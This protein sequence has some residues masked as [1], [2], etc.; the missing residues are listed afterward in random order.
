MSIVTSVLIGRI[1]LLFQYK[2][3]TAGF[4][5]YKVAAATHTI[6]ASKNAEQGVD[7]IVDSLR[8]SAG[9]LMYRCYRA[10]GETSHE[11]THHQYPLLVN[12]LNEVA[13][14]WNFYTTHVRPVINDVNNNSFIG[15]LPTREMRRLRSLVK[16]CNQVECV[17]SE[18][19]LVDNKTISTCLTIVGNDV[20]QFIKAD[21]VQELLSLKKA[22]DKLSVCWFTWLALLPR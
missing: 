20:V 18:L 14:F 3:T 6:L 7:N 4:R 5:L 12:D 13:D 2:Q 16:L 10:F 15:W 17:I 9:K 11:N 22:Y 1:I 8:Y 19:I 21:D